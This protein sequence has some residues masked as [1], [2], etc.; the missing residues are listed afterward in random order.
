MIT[1]TKEKYEQDLIKARQDMLNEISICVTMYMNKVS[2]LQS[3]RTEAI[4]NETK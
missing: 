3:K 2:Y 1:Y 4:K